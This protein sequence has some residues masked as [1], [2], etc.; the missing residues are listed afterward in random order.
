MK[1]TSNTVL[2]QNQR[3]FKKGHRK[4][5]DCEELCM[6]RTYVVHIQREIQVNF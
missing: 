5:L 3:D 1:L 6:I 4:V 2:T